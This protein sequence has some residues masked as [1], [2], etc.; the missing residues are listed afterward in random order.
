MYIYIADPALK[1]MMTRPDLVGRSQKSLIQPIHPI[2]SPQSGI[3]SS[4]LIALICTRSRRTR[5]SASAKQGHGQ[6]DLI[7][8]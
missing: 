2:T 5:A 6:G 1:R 7:L 3:K 4:F 8:F